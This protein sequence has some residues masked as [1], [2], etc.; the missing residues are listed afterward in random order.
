MTGEID[1]PQVS[2]SEEK[3]LQTLPEV[4]KIGLKS[5]PGSIETLR[6]NESQHSV[7]LL[8]TSGNI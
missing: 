7:L 3:R 4:V 6:A 8:T 5:E 2:E 1:A